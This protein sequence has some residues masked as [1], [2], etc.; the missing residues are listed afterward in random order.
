MEI[1]HSI[2]TQS[3]KERTEKYY[4]NETDDIPNIKKTS[5]HYSM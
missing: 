4:S 3:K 2:I 1:K 5:T